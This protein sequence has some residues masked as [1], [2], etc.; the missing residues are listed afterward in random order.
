MDLDDRLLRAISDFAGNESNLEPGD[1]RHP[2]SDPDSADEDQ[3]HNHKDDNDDDYNDS[4]DSDSE[5]LPPMPPGLARENALE[6]EDAAIR[7]HMDSAGPQTGPKGVLAD[8]KFHKQQQRAR[9]ELKAQ[10]DYQK[11]S[12]GAL[13]SGWMQRSVAEEERR[14]MGLPD[15]AKAAGRQRND[16]DEDEDDEDMEEELFLKAYRAKR[17]AQFSKQRFQTGKQFGTVI[18]MESPDEY[19]NAIDDEAPSVTVLVHLY[20][21]SNEGCRVV[22]ALLSVLAAR[23]ATNTKFC[24]IKSHIA[25]ETFDLVVLPAI[26]AYKN[27]EIIGTAMRVLD[28][29]DTWKQSG[30]CTA[31]DLEAVLAQQGILGSDEDAIFSANAGLGGVRLYS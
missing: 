23:H 30:R 25:D 12:S 3:A 16:D 21:P 9:R 19:L 28:D 14:K 7:R 10:R 20:Q 24:K 15:V 1:R 17:M 18:E 22:N 8:Q 13:A 11:L 26:L 5:G 6:A 4:D 31:E 27:G 2:D 29:V